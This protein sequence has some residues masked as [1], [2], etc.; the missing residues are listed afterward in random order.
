MDRGRPERARG[1]G[2]GLA[3]LA[4]LAAF[5]GAWAHSKRWEAI[6]FYQFWLVSRV[7]S[8][9]EAGD[10]YSQAERDRL[11]AE[12]QEQAQAYGGQGGGRRERAASQ[13]GT[14]ETYSTPWLYARFAPFTGGYLVAR[15][16]FQRIS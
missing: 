4:A 13:R 12:F 15:T 14:I 5:A 6:D 9:G 3:V 1:V 11:G 10:I 8:R 16:R 7:V 2:L